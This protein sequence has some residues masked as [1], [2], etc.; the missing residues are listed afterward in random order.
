[1]FVYNGSIPH[2]ELKSI[3]TTH[4]KTKSISMLTQKPSDSRPA[5]K[6]KL[7]STTHTKTKSVDY[8]T[9]SKSISARTQLISTPPQKKQVKIDTRATTKSNSIPRTKVKFLSTPLLKSNQFDPYSKIQVNVDAPT[10]TKTNLSSIHTLKPSI[11][12]PPHQ[13]QVNSDPYPE[14]KTCSITHA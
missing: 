11:F 5:S 9:E 13:N 10:D 8:H 3:S 4:T 7:I 1:M 14:I 12:L 2:T 6:T